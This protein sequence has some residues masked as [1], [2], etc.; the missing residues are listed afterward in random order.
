[1]QSSDKGKGQMFYLGVHTLKMLDCPLGTAFRSISSI[2]SQLHPPPWAYS[3]HHEL[4]VNSSPLLAS[5]A[6]VMYHGTLS[7]L[8]AVFF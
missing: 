1:M 3:A 7:H 8:S 4:Q 6:S 5:S 2:S